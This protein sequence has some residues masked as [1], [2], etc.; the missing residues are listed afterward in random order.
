V[1]AGVPDNSYFYFVHSYYA[2][3]LDQRHTAG[4]TDYGQSFTSAI[5]RDNIF[6]T[7]FHPEKSADLGFDALPAISLLVTLTCHHHHHSVTMLLIPAIDLK[8]GHCV[9]LKQGDMDQSTTFGED[10]A[11]MALQMGEQRRTAL[12]PGGPERRVC[13]QAQNYE[14]PS[15]AS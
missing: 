3:P 5:S 2:R 7:Q 13:R 4:V 1:W 8:D 9:R 6:A 12:A 14:R 15:A 11:D 10:P